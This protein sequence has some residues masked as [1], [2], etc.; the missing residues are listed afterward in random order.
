MDPA[1]FQQAGLQNRH[2]GLPAWVV[3]A[4]CLLGVIG[5]GVNDYLDASKQTWSTLKQFDEDEKK[6]GGPAEI[7]SLE[8]QTSLGTIKGPLLELCFRPPAG[9]NQPPVLLTPPNQ[10]LKVL[11]YASADGRPS[12]PIAGMWLVVMPGR[13]AK[14]LREELAKTTLFTLGEG[15][16]DKTTLKSAGTRGVLNAEWFKP[17]NKPA[18]PAPTAPPAAPV[19]PANSK[20]KA[21]PPAP[22]ASPVPA[23]QAQP[24]AIA[25]VLP[26]EQPQEPSQIALVYQPV[27]GMEAAARDLAMRSAATA[28]TL[29][30]AASERARLTRKKAAPG[31]GKAPPGAP[32]TPSAQPQEG[33]A[34]GARP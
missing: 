27:P 9:F 17:A 15:S 28:R 6:L 12:G 24:A 21:P 16:W 1:C 13:D 10:P 2:P 19:Q 5:C 25:F 3:G 7:P 20:G 22:K 34:G 18:Q 11:Q 29:A 31:G 30:A 32:G 26:Y 23:A 14:P 8:R 33:A 4:A